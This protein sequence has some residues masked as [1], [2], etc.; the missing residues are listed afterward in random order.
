VP[1]RRLASRGALGKNPRV[2][3]DIDHLP[4]AQ[5]EELAQVTQILMDEFAVATSRATQPWKKNGKVQK[6]ALFG[7]YARGD[8]VDEP[9]NGYQ[10]D[11]DLLVIVSHADLTDI[12]EYWYVAEDRILRDPAIGRPVNIIVHTLAEVNQGL[13]RGEYF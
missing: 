1:Q 3:T 9:D 5:Q 11:Y 10:S 7:S 8:W 13:T 12:A 6:I 4:P 2:K